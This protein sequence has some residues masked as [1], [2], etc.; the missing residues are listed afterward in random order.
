M[1]HISDHSHYRLNEVIALGERS[2]G[3]IY[4][5][6]AIQRAHYSND[7]THNVGSIKFQKGIRGDYG[8]I[9]GVSDIDL[10]EILK[11]RLV[12]FQRT[13]IASDENDQALK[14]V[15]EALF[16]LNKRMEDRTKR[17]VIGMMD[18]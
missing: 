5:E 11:H 18:K 1:K 15:E 17:G 12:A 16:W 6:Y 7:S 2:H 4:Y 10:L 8:V 9:N 13:S 14:H 3:G